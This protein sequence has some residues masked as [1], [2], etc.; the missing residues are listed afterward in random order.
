MGDG[1]FAAYF[2]Q[3]ARFAEVFGKYGIV[4]NTAFWAIVMNDVLKEHFRPAKTVQF[5][6]LII[7]QHV[8]NRTHHP[9]GMRRANRAHLCRAH[10]SLPRETDL[11]SVGLGG[12]AGIPP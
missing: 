8:C 10:F 7:Q 4:E 9:I 2:Q 3:A 11:H 6:Y 1:A 5:R 12:V